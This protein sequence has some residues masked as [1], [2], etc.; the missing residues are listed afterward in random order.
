MAHDVVHGDGHDHAHPPHLAHHFDTPE[1][2]FDASKLGMWAFLATEVLM[3][4]GLFCAYAVYRYNN[5]G[6]FR[7][8]EHHVNTWWGALN[9]IILLTSSLTMAMGVRAAQ[10]GQQKTLAALLVATILGG[11]GFMVI[12]AI[13]YNDKWNHGLFPGLFNRYDRV[14]NE[15]AFVAARQGDHGEGEHA[16]EGSAQEHAA[17]GDRGGADGHASPPGVTGVPEQMPRQGEHPQPGEAATQATTQLAQAPPPDLSF[18]GPSYVDPNY[19]TSD[20][21]KVRPSFQTRPGLADQSHDAHA[22]VE[23]DDLVFRE[24]AQV[25]KFFNIYFMMTGLHGLHVVVGIALI[26]WILLRAASQHVRG[27]ILACATLGVSA[28]LIF[29]GALT[30]GGTIFWITT[31]VIGGGG[32]LWLGMAMVQSR[33]IAAT[34]GEFG[35]EFFTP[36]DLVG[37][38]WHLVDLIWIFLFPLL[39]LIH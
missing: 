21:A 3:F 19:H 36:V 35:P 33:Q 17:P 8:G 1:Q 28:Y 15:P 10:L 25:A 26:T 29:V 22:G 4:G 24:Q 34:A 37:L 30:G 12:K 38:Y 11:A 27:I 32:M 9:T 23:Y 7:Y 6:V 16:A 2:Q 18:L 20:V 39:Y 13:E 5:P 31:A 14:Q